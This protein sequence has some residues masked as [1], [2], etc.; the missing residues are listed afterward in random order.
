[1]NTGK[2]DKKKLLVLGG[3]GFVSGHVVRE[4]LA[5]GHEVWVVT[6]GN[7]PAPAGTVALRA[8]RKDRAEFARVIREAGVFWDGVMDCIC[9]EP[10][11][12]VQDVELFRT[13]A[14]QVVMVSTDFVY[15]P[16]F[17]RFPQGEESDHYLTS[18]YG[19]R[20][21]ACEQVFLGSDTGAM[22]WTVIRTGH[23]YG[24]GSKLG[25][26]P[27][28]ARD[29]HLIERMRAGEPLDLVGAGHFLQHPNFAP[30]LARLMI[31]CIGNSR[32][33]NEI[34]ISGGP[35][36]LEAREY[37]AIIAD[38][39]GV[40]LKIREV[41]IEAYKHDHPDDCPFLCNRIYDL[42]KLKQAGVAVP[43]TPIEEGLRMHVENVLNAGG[44]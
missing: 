18:G 39:L 16:D 32:T 9:M 33:F 23:V 20:K 41:P 13:H 27:C 8:D 11:D 42:T 40:P 14:A 5:Q 1:M 30:D 36:A 38:I 28:H 4:A 21:R 31:S 22:H 15:D 34:F 3:T 29:A 10:D 2:T 12:A 37:F 35:R 7:H 43:D 6:R 19:G 24:P 25:G 17:I 26:M 44:V